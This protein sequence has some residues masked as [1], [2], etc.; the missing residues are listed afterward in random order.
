MT[1]ALD[2]CRPRD[3]KGRYLRVPG[4][5]TAFHVRLLDGRWWPV[6]E[7][8]R[9]DERGVCRMV[10][11]GDV[12]ALAAAV[13]AGKSAMGNPPGG[14]F[15]VNEFGQVIVPAGA[16][17]GR[18]VIVGECQG[19][20]AFHD[21]FDGGVFDM[22]DGGGLTSG[23]PWHRPYVGIRHNLSA[24]GQVY[25]AETGASGMRYVNPP[26]EPTALIAAL[27]AIRPYGPVR[28]LVG[29]GGIVLTKVEPL[30]EPRYV[31][32]IDFDCWFEKEE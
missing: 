23:A 3:W 31:G 10:D 9:N 32:Q 15:L 13:N 19:D 18:V 14:A 17:S 16:E 7:L 1:L 29:S 30:W 28:F 11:D 24:R 2:S 26:T 21:P 25:F 20:F 8:D 4:E 22:A 12:A 27:R 5:T 6:A